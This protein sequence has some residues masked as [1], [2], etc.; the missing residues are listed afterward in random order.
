MKLN[1]KPI[2]FDKIE[3]KQRITKRAQQ[4]IN[5]IHHMSNMF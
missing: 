4:E 2:C 1:E 3:T 5:E